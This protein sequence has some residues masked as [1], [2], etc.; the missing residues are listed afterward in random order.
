LIVE[1]GENIREEQIL[2]SA[3]ET[4]LGANPEWP[5]TANMIITSVQI[6]RALF[7]S[8]P[9]EVRREL[10]RIVAWELMEA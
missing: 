10:A 8:A 6:W 2:K 9:P 1:R 7:P 3:V 5:L 4:A